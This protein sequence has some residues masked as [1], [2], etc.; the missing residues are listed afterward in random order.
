MYPLS[1]SWNH[2]QKIG[3]NTCDIYVWS[4]F[5][6]QP[7]TLSE[8]WTTVY[9]YFTIVIL[10]PKRFYNKWKNKEVLYF[11]NFYISD[12]S[13]MA[14]RTGWNEAKDRIWSKSQK[15]ILWN[16]Q[17]S[18][19]DKQEERKS[20]KETERETVIIFTFM[21]FTQEANT[22]HMENETILILQIIYCSIKILVNTSS[23]SKENQ[24]WKCTV[25]QRINFFVFT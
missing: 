5:R 3:N 7:P 18:R 19:K 4:N 15:F 11:T 13:K 24:I 23:E 12:N 1:C 16:Q 25:Y 10:N 9:N 20:Y 2:A 22:F 21:N 14:L 8:P 17:Y 6:T